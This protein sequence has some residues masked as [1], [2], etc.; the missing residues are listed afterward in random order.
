MKFKFEKAG[1]A[2][3]LGVQILSVVLSVYALVVVS[4]PLFQ[5]GS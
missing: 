1:L 2:E 4:V 3:R 5:I